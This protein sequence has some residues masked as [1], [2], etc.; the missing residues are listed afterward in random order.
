MHSS[1]YWAVHAIP[2]C[3]TLA[4]PAPLGHALVAERK[5]LWPIGSTVTV[6]VRNATFRQW[7]LD[8]WQ[9][10]VNLKLLALAD[11]E[12]AD[13]RIDANP[14]RGNWSVLGS[15]APVPKTDPTMNIADVSLP[16]VWLHEFGH[17][18]G[19]H[20]EHQSPESPI[21]WN[22]PAVY[23]DMALLGWNQ[24]KVDANV[25]YQYDRRAEATAF[26]AQSVMGYPI[27]G[28]WTQNFPRGIQ[29][30][31]ALSALDKAGARMFYPQ[32]SDAQRVKWIKALYDEMLGRQPDEY[33]LKFWLSHGD[34][35]VIVDGIMHSSEYWAVHVTALYEA[36]LGRPATPE[37]L[38][39]WGQTPLAEVEA[40]ILASEEYFQGAINR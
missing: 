14:T 16:W 18:L 10:H 23:R 17:A 24:A 37:D 33:G 22:K 5:Y 40:G 35:R 8:Q 38:A 26:D 13:I 12:R 6:A 27:P 1:D 29:P 32:A 11:W 31:Q 34:R 2:I 3:S 19:F 20:H 4:P 30:G 39:S 36:L 28:H 15:G 25:F 21:I 7:V 9:P